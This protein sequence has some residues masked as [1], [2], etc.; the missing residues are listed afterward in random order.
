MPWWIKVYVIFLYHQ[1]TV[2]V[3]TLLHKQTC[4]TPK[5]IWITHLLLCAAFYLPSVI[6]SVRNRKHT[7]KF[8]V[9][10]ILM[11]VALST[12]LHLT[13]I[14]QFH[15][16]KSLLFYMMITHAMW[17]E[18]QFLRSRPGVL[19]FQT[20]ICRVQLF[21]I[22]FIPALGLLMCPRTMRTSPSFL[23]TLI[24]IFA[25]EIMGFAVNLT[26]TLF[27]GVGSAWETI[28]II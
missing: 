14:E 27:E 22:A 19:L 26:A 23:S 15:Q 24:I 1:S 18:A 11:N 28:F 12:I 25:S 13:Y 4:L 20:M 8:V 6:H 7:T 5:S 3:A 21:L 17:C 10:T 9:N 16:S 2:D